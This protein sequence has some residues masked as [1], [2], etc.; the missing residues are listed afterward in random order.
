MKVN[1]YVILALLFILILLGG[2]LLSLRYKQISS[3]KAV[4]LPGV[5]PVVTQIKNVDTPDGTKTLHM[6]VINNKDNSNTYRFT[7]T[8]TTGGNISILTKTLSAGKTM[9]LSQNAWSP[10]NNYFFIQEND[11][12]KIVG[13]YV[14]KWNGQMFSDG[15]QFINMFDLYQKKVT[16]YIFK[17]ATGWA[18]ETLIIINTLNIDGSRGVSFWFDIPSKSFIP[19]ATKF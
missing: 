12:K 19:L 11:G 5:V 15:E 9:S 18:A 4:V 1:K 3:E 16:N 2:A 13:I 6:K 10:D 14:Y 7:V 17:E 8:T